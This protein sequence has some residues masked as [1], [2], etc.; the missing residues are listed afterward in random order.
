MSDGFNLDL[1]SAEDEIDVPEDFDGQVTL[2]VLDGTTPDS[3]W[4]GVIEAGNVLFL[5]VDGDLNELAAGFAK[6]VKEDG[7]TLMHFREF[8]VVTPP[9]IGVDADRL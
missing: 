7:A 1:R 9:G 8:L 4:I 2:G 3:E 5:A 6:D